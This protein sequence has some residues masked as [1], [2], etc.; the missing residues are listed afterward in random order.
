MLD[1]ANFLKIPFRPLNK[2]E[3]HLIRNLESFLTTM[4][5]LLKRRAGGVVTTMPVDLSSLAAS[6]LFEFTF[7]KE[8]VIYLSFADQDIANGSTLPTELSFYMKSLSIN[9]VIEKQPSLLTSLLSDQ[10]RLNLDDRLRASLLHMHAETISEKRKNS[11]LVAVSCTRE[12]YYSSLHPR[13]GCL[14]SADLLPFSELYLTEVKQLAYY[15]LE[16][17]TFSGELREGLAKFLDESMRDKKTEA[18]SY[19]AP[20]RRLSRGGAPE[21]RA[22]EILLSI[23]NRNFLKLKEVRNADSLHGLRNY[24]S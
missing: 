9:P 3:T 16:K 13:G 21:T 20:I 7:G 6:I 4:S 14:H 2:Q 1:R 5:A 11:F 17:G 18:S 10:V 8:N 24:C 22:D 15:L 23:A 12:S 19:E